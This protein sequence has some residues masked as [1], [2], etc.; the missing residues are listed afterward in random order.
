MFTQ[1]ISSLLRNL[2]LPKF[3]NE[4]ITDKEDLYKI[5]DKVIISNSV[6]TLEQKDVA[7]FVLEKILEICRNSEENVVWDKEVVAECASKMLDDIKTR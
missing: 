6:T 4:K 7:I 5:I 1:N 3:E 2:T